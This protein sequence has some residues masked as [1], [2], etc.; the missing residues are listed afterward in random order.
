MSRKTK[1]IVFYRHL[2][3]EAAH[4][5]WRRKLLWIFGLFAGILSTGS[6]LDI[7]LRH[8]NRIER[9]GWTVDQMILGV[10]PEWDYAEIFR[11]SAGF[12]EPL[13]GRVLFGVMAVIFVI[14]IALSL[15]SQSVIIT[16]ASNEHIVWKEAWE[17]SYEHLS[18]LLL[19]NVMWKLVQWILLLLTSLPLALV[20]L[21]ATVANATLYFGLF[22]LL[23]PLGIIAN[24]IFNL[25][26]I[27]V[28]RNRADAM[29]ALHASVSLFKKHWLASLELS[30]IV[31]VCSLIGW[32]VFLL[33][34]ALFFIPSTIL[35]TAALLSGLPFLFSFFTGFCIFAY[36]I[37]FSFFFGMMV[38]FQYA[39]WVRFH[40]RAANRILGKRI[41]GKLERVW[42][43]S[44]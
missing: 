17:K 33:A 40:E 20:L 44:R 22:L 18:D 4:F 34:A 8:F 21:E 1:T 6:V 24:T 5:A 11:F 41:F 25:A 16:A 7:T 39:A 42:G 2:I 3:A 10:F 28:A 38:L 37:G 31:F 29:H 26:I 15:R 27:E 9:V 32:S 30:I 23:F 14:V 13:H 36:F 19:L 12:L 35:V 43:G